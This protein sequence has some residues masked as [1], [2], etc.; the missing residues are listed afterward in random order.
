MYIFDQFIIIFHSFEA[1]NWA[2]N[3]ASNEWKI[4]TNNSAAQGLLIFYFFLHF[5][6]LQTSVLRRSPFW[7]DTFPRFW[8][9]LGW[10]QM[11]WSRSGAYS[12][13]SCTGRPS[14]KIWHGL[15]F[16]GSTPRPVQMCF[17]W[18]ISWWPSLW[19]MLNVSEGSVWWKWRR[20]NTEPASGH[21]YWRHTEDPDVIPRCYRVRPSGGCWAVAPGQS[22]VQTCGLRLL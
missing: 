18:W 1:E 20:T 17:T 7:R 3:P 9:R 6:S 19:L 21:Q 14:G 15:R 16:M 5:V 11:Q 8:R 12:R 2:S 4:L 10:H 22:Q 13:L